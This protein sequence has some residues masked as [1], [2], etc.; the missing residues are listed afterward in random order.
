LAHEI[1]SPLEIELPTTQLLERFRQPA[2]LLQ[3]FDLRRIFP[4]FAG[5]RLDDLF[6]GLK[7]PDG[8]DD[9]IRI[10]HGTDPQ[11]VRG[12][13]QVDVDQPF[14]RAVTLFTFAG[15]VMQVQGGRFRA[16]SR[17]EGGLGQPPRQTFQGEISGDW[18]VTVGGFQ[19]LIVER[20]PLK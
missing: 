2:D 10:T 18:A 12:W 3:N 5:L 4:N 1:V 17:I 8:A 9:R 6:E 7:L 14:D 13:V 16:K 15:V 11:S 20:T 19:L